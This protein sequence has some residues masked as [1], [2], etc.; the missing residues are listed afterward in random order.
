MGGEIL[1]ESAKRDIE[2]L[3]AHGMNIADGAAI[4]AVTAGQ[5]RAALAA[6]RH[7]QADAYVVSCAIAHTAEI[8][9]EMEQHLGAPVLTS[10]QVTLWHALRQAGIADSIGGFGKLFADC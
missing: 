8:I 4:A 6:Q 10:N 3:A 1:T 7:T 5:W 9:E 2:T